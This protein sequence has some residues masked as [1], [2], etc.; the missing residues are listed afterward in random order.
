[1]SRATIAACAILL[2]VQPAVSQESGL[3]GFFPHADSVCLYPRT[4]KK[5]RVICS[6]KIDRRYVTFVGYAGD[7]RVLLAAVTLNPLKDVQDSISL[8]VDFVDNR[9]SA[10]KITPWGNVYDRNKDG[11]IDYLAIVG[12]AAAFKPRE[13]PEDFPLRGGHMTDAQIDYFV[14]H[15]A[16]IFNHWA[17]DNFDGRLDAAV[18]AD[19]DPERDWVERRIVVRSTKFNGRYD[20]VWAFTGSIGDERD[21]VGHTSG[22]VPYHPVMKPQEEIGPALFAERTNI[23][24][25][26][27]GAAKECG[28]KAKSFYPVTEAEEGR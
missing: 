8:L 6:R 17:D 15:C 7:T 9:V 16:I 10:G 22:G 25:L 26:M 19:M 13:F 5:L 24:K 28:L 12:G 4:D 1:M 18:Q 27:N 20:D 2:F 3:P 21:S 14:G 11:K 23:L